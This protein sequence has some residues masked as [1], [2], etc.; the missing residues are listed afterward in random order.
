LDDHSSRIVIANNL[1]RSYPEASFWPNLNAP[2][3]DLAPCRVLLFSLQQ[4]LEGFPFPA[5]KSLPWTFSLFHCSS[6]YDGGALPLALPCGVR[7]FLFY[8]KNNSPSKLMENYYYKS[9]HPRN[10]GKITLFA[11]FIKTVFFL[12]DFK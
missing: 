4:L 5:L 12:E 9:D 3:F 11:I 7:T 8:F 1:K 2:L 10:T 6:P